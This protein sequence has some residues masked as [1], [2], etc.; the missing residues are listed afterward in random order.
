MTTR[1]IRLFLYGL[2]AGVLAA[3]LLRTAGPTAPIPYHGTVLLFPLGGE[4]LVIGATKRH[5]T[6]AEC[7]AWVDSGRPSAE[8]DVLSTHIII[9][10][11][12]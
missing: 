4:G 6:L 2:L 3:Y 5:A 1:D 10:E 7:Q 12:R 11:C 9:A 8:S